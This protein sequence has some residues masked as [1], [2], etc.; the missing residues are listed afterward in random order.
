MPDF[1]R[2]SGPLSAISRNPGF[3]GAG[4]F[5]GKKENPA[6]KYQNHPGISPGSFG[7]GGWVSRVRAQFCPILRGE[8]FISLF[9]SYLCVSYLE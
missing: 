1:C 3:Q 9:S 5:N 8:G 6:E 2:F 4:Q 7:M